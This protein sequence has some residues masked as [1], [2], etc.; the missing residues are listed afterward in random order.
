V[1][2]T[3]LCSS[4][5]ESPLLV[6]YTHSNS[7][8]KIQGTAHPQT[9]NTA[10]LSTNSTNEA[11][12]TAAG[13][14]SREPT[15]VWGPLRPPPC[16]HKGAWPVPVATPQN[17]GKKK[18]ESSIC[19]LA[20]KKKKKVNFLLRVR[21]PLRNLHNV[22]KPPAPLCVRRPRERQKPRGR[23]CACAGRGA[24][25]TPRE[26]LCASAHAPL[27]S[28]PRES[29]PQPVRCSEHN[30]CNAEAG[31]RRPPATPLE[32][33]QGVEVPPST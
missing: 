5:H 16:S 21:A 6:M 12:G 24:R 25:D 14:K 4:H 33:W 17:A 27:G 11:K 20:L 7:V 2:G 15:K 31:E 1:H 26:R 30:R 32:R 23:H 22:R 13:N 28:P 9:Q 18:G 3:R 8:F 19:T 10:Y 29:R